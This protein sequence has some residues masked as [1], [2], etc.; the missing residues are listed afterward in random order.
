VGNIAGFPYRC[1]SHV[2]RSWLAAAKSDF[3]AAKAEMQKAMA[4]APTDL[5]PALSDLLRQLESGVDI[6]K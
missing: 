4:A 6:N 1:R 3:A 2:A 5:K